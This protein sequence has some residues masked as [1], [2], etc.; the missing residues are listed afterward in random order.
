MNSI[1][2]KTTKR[3][4]LLGTL[5]ILALALIM[6]LSGISTAFADQSSGVVDGTSENPAKAS[7]TKIFKMP[8]GTTAPADGFTFTF[9]VAAK[10]VNEVNATNEDNPT[11]MPAIVDKTISVSKVQAEGVTPADGVLTYTNQ[12]SDILSGLSWPAT[13]VYVYDI[14]EKTTGSE[15]AS[16]G[17]TT[18]TETLTNSTAKYELTVWVKDNDGTKYVAGVAT[19]IKSIDNIGQGEVNSKVDA[20]P[21]TEGTFSAMTFT[22]TYVKTIETTTES[23]GAGVL[24]IAHA[25]TGDLSD[26]AAEFPY[27]ITLTAPSVATGTTFSAKVITT[28]D[29]Q[30]VDS[31]TIT[32]SEG[33]ANFTLKAGEALIFDT[34]P[35]G[36]QY[37][38]TD[39][40]TGFGSYT[41]SCIS[42]NGGTTGEK[43]SGQ[44]GTALTAPASGA[45]Y[46]TEGSDITAF[47][48]DYA[49][50]AFTGL[51]LNNLPYIL[52]ILLAVAIVAV[53]FVSRSRRRSYEA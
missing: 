26:S 16:D 14:T 21:G 28:S 48:N 52:M 15:F 34:L 30:A 32:F 7:I 33:T 22:N 3:S 23:P 20:S 44:K 49:G 39:S 38:V 47:S 25:V 46:V 4:R 50:V 29:N 8:V 13:G 31:K 53:Y 41:P 2:F 42:T 45:L 40:L 27:S 24:K 43:V 5:S 35:V 11:N 36:T 1:K 51:V 12:T 10:T 6:S 19:T 17:I 37:T 18:T 9:D